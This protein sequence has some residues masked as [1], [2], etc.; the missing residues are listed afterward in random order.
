MIRQRV[1]ESNKALDTTQSL[2][3][4]NLHAVQR[5]TAQ[6]RRISSS[7]CGTLFQDIKILVLIGIVLF[8]CFILIFIL[9]KPKR[10]LFL[11]CCNPMETPGVSLH[12]N[13]RL[14]SAY[15]VYSLHS[16]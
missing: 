7:F 12:T 1:V 6:I 15:V 11:V 16:L 4:N 3:E 13:H 14:F 2:Q 9:P 10:K 5:E 8:V